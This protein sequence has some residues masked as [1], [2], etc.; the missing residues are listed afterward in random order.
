M[1]RRRCKSIFC[2]LL[3]GFWLSCLWGSGCTDNPDA[4]AAKEMRKQ[5]ALAV[6]MSAVGKDY[7]AAQQK[8]LASLERGV[9]GGLTK[10]TALLASGNLAMAKGQQI[11]ADLDAIALQIRT[12]TNKLEDILRSSEDI[13]IE[14]E[15]GE[16]L[17]AVEDQ[18]IAELGHLLNGEGQLNE[19][20]EQVDAKRRQLL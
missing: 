10:D 13:L 5:T 8:V 3:A 11:Q 17:L 14:K 1:G 4:K 2:I 7:E 18:E 16:M 6:Q 15:R 20:L 9:S 12:S 19:Q